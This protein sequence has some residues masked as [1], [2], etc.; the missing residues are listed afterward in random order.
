MRNYHTAIWIVTIVLTT[1][2]SVV[3]AASFQGIDMPPGPGWKS[4]PKGLSSSS[5]IVGGNWKWEAGLY[6]TVAGLPSDFTFEDISNNGFVAIASGTSQG[7]VF[8]MVVN[9]T[10]QAVPGYPGDTFTYPK[11]VSADGSKIVGSTRGE[12]AWVYE[13]GAYAGLFVPPDYTA[14]YA[15]AISSDGSVIAGGVS[16]GG[17][18]RTVVWT[19]D[20]IQI[21][22][23]P[24]NETYS[25]PWEI[26]GDG[27]TVVGHYSSNNFLPCIW[28]NGTIVPLPLLPGV[29]SAT[30]TNVSFDGSLVF[31]NSMDSNLNPNGNAFIWD[32][33]NGTR[34][35]ADFLQ[36]DFGLN[37]EGWNLMGVSATDDSGNIIVGSG[38]NPQGQQELWIATIPEPATI[39]LFGLGAALLWRR[40]S[41]KTA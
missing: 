29:T 36:N 25:I 4:Y 40:K 35:L 37:L 34:L 15:R 18:N 3:F 26:S 7:N 32:Q 17:V 2:Q 22:P 39:I 27:S 14:G 41:A 11:A 9:S 1:L 10:V 23:N 24:A 21:L 33:T 13:N 20:G 6:A 31:G 5:V 28:R 30:A 16:G 8:Y 19:S 38:I 12:K